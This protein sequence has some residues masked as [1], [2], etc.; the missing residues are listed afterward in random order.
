MLPIVEYGS[1]AIVVSKISALGSV[2]EANGKYGFHVYCTGNDAPFSV[3]FTSKKEAEDNREELIAIIARYYF[4]RD[5]GPDFDERNLDSMIG[6][7]EVEEDG[8]DDDDNR[9]EK[10]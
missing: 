9:K 4:V 1:I 10:H 3:Y 2:I 5:F 7:N 8:G 6:D